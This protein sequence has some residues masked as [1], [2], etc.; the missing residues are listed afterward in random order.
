MI[1]IN[2]YGNLACVITSFIYGHKCRARPPRDPIAICSTKPKVF[3][4]T[5]QFAQSPA[6]TSLLEDDLE[7]P[8]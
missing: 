8:A 4:D 3:L 7:L 1:H 2:E 6:E 5:S